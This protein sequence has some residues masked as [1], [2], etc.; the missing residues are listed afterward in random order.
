M[1]LTIDDWVDIEWEMQRALHE[2]YEWTRQTSPELIELGWIAKPDEW[3]SR[4]EIYGECARRLSAQH[5]FSMGHVVTGSR[6]KWK[7]K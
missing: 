1:R 4:E 6:R 5:N 7:R 3:R 2:N